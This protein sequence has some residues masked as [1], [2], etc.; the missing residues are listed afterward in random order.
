MQVQDKIKHFYLD[1]Q[2]LDKDKNKG[3]ILHSNPHHKMHR[4]GKI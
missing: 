2:E 3:N 1:I 4:Q